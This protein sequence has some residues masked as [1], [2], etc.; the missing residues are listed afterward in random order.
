MPVHSADI[1]AIFDEI[2]EQGRDLAAG[3]RDDRLTKA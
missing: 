2:A 1:A 3:V